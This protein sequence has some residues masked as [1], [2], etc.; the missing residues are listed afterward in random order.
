MVLES[1]S[2][3]L[4]RIQIG[5]KFNTKLKTKSRLNPPSNAQLKITVFKSSPARRAADLL[6]GYNVIT[7]LILASA[8]LNSERLGRGK[9]LVNRCSDF[10]PPS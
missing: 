8:A 3:D 1:I 10:F 5:F 2:I 7:T 6:N 4:L 9:V